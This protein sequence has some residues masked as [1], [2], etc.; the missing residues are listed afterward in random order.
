MKTFL[1]ILLCWLCSTIIAQDSIL[2]KPIQYKNSIQVQDEFNFID[3]NSSKA[4]HLASIEYGYKFKNSPFVAR[5]NYINKFNLNAT[6]FEVD[7]YP[8]LSKK[9][10]CYVNIGYSN[11]VLFPGYKAGAS[12]YFSLP[13]SF[14][15]EGGFR[16]LQYSTPVFVYTGSVGKY[17]KRFW[18]N[19][20]GYA[21]P[22]NGNIST[23]C[24]LKTR[25]Y[26][27][28]SNFFMLLVGKG[29]SPDDKNHSNNILFNSK[30]NSFTAEVSMEKKLNRH[31]I[32]KAKSGWFSQEDIESSYSNQWMAGLGLKWIF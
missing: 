7:A 29:I 27:N 3:N 17:Y 26:T 23:S 20:T 11:A 19:L 8:S 9:I 10:Y 22:A 6:Q 25:Y 21:V 32:L 18:F 24:F 4:W 16:Y 1:T 13:H 31:F 2:N 14:E 28:E 5:F 15:I 30:R 12:V